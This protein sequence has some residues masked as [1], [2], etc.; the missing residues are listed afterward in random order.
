MM[1]QVRI[2]VAALKERCHAGT[3]ADSMR[4]CLVDEFSTSIILQPLQR[5]MPS[6]ANAISGNPFF[7][8]IV[9]QA[10]IPV[11]EVIGAHAPRWMQF[12]DCRARTLLLRVTPAF[13]GRPGRARH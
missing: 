11:V 7:Q 3:G 13:L 9:Q 12:P 8:T 5:Q 1:T 2:G 4:R 6:A 10:F